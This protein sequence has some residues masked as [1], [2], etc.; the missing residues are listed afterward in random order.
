M[1]TD[2][3]EE[4]SEE[5]SSSSEDEAPQRPVP[6]AAPRRRKGD[7]EPDPEQMRRDMER[8]ALIRQKRCARLP[9]WGAGCAR[10]LLLS[11][12]GCFCRPCPP[13][14]APLPTRAP[15]PN[16]RRACPV[17]RGGAAEAD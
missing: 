7:D 11:L 13:Q 15:A 14:T 16:P 4:S 6:A 8:L 12:P 9:G 2:S 17:Q 5:E 10:A 1:P 3:E